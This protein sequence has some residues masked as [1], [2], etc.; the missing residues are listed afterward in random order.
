MKPH[1][2][3][4]KPHIYFLIIKFQYF[5]VGALIEMKPH[6]SEMKPHIC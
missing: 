3:E 6:T 2:S 4:M 5:I 1:I